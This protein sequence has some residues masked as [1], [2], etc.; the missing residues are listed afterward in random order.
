MK[1]NIIYPVLLA[2]SVGIF[3]GCVTQK[4]V[5]SVTVD[6]ALSTL[7]PDSANMA[8]MQ[9]TFNVPGKYFSK[10]VWYFSSIGCR[11]QCALNTNHLCDTPIYS[12]KKHRKEVLPNMRIRMPT[13][14]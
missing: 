3:A 14:G 2:T 1:R 4:N 11:G 9:V 8:Q 6:P 7:T 13:S 12:K 10:V 5:K